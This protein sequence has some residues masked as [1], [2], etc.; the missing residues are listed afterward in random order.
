LYL[1]EDK[2]D[3]YGFLKRKEMEVF[4]ILN[5]ISGVGP[6]SALYLSSCGSIE[7]LKDDMENGKLKVKGIGEKRMQKILLEL[8]GMIKEMK[9]EENVSDEAIDALSSLG[10]SVKDAKELLKKI[11]KGIEKTEDKVKEVLKLVGK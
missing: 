9:K 5:N 7:K 6:K 1:K 11:P 8:T 10:F 4:K 3:L 2:M